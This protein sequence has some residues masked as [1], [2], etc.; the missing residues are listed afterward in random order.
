MFAALRLAV[1][2]TAG[3]TF[4]AYAQGP[5]AGNPNIV[6]DQVVARAW[7]DGDFKAKLLSDPRSVLAEHGIHIPDTTD[8]RVVEDTMER[9]HLLLP[10][11]PDNASAMS[12]E[13]LEKAAAEK[14]ATAG[15][16]APATH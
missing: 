3:L 13:D 5:G 6:W 4:S 14:T 9:R 2:F 11:A 10:V 7:T 15:R 16:P 12:T 8:V 1:A